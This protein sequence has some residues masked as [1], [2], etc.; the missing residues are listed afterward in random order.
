MGEAGARTTGPPRG[1]EIDGQSNVSDARRCLAQI[2]S[3]SPGSGPRRAPRQEAEQQPPRL[4]GFP[5]WPSDRA[6]ED[7]MPRDAGQAERMLCHRAELVS[8]ASH[9]S[10]KSTTRACA[11]ERRFVREDAKRR[12]QTGASP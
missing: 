5:L 9:P 8:P 4:N 7:R 10:R 6:G 2:R 11:V 3:T 12:R 1:A